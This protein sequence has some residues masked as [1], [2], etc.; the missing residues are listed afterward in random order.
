MRRSALILVAVLAVVLAPAIS[1]GQ[2]TRKPSTARSHFTDGIIGQFDTSAADLL[3]APA[4]ISAKFTAAT[5]ER[6]PILLI[7]AKIASG[8]HTYSVTQ[9]P[10]GP[11]PTSI[12]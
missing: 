5:S 9:P 4:T 1:N 7:T 11:Q 12:E 6:R 2:T 8:R 3:A 10:G